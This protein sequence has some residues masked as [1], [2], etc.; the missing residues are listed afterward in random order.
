M[1]AAKTHRNYFFLIWRSHSDSFLVCKFL[2]SASFQLLRLSFI[3]FFEAKV[4]LEFRPMDMEMWDEFCPMDM[5]K[6]KGLSQNK[7][8]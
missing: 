4:F 1:W 2:I 3:R 8:E 6:K 5:E 7:I